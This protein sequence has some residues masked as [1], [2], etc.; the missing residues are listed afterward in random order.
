[1]SF[2]GFNS[3]YVFIVIASIALI[4]GLV[5]IALRRDDGNRNQ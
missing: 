4:V 1:M 5:M 2:A 3:L